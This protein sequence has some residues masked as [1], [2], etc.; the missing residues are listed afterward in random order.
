MAGGPSTP[1]LTAAVSNAGGLGFLGGAFLSPKDLDEAL[2]RIKQLTSR[3]FGINLFIPER[4]VS[5]SGDQIAAALYATKKFRTELQLPDPNLKPP[6]QEDFHQQ[7][8]VVLKHDLRY[9]VLSLVC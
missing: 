3:P 7:I 4:Q 2:T 6:F 8:A 1:E 5:I 9:L